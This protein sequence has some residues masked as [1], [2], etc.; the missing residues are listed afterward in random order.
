MLQNFVLHLYWVSLH[1]LFGSAHACSCER[2][3]QLWMLNVFYSILQCYV[4][5]LWPVLF[6][7]LWLLL[8]LSI[9]DVFVLL[10]AH[11]C[12][13]SNYLWQLSEREREIKME[14][15]Q[16]KWN[17]ITE[18]CSKT[19]RQRINKEK[20]KE[21]KKTNFFLISVQNLDAI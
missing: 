4:T 10:L 15:E 16:V 2:W 5:I 20:E 18:M 3:M 14:R 8:L 9:Y 6:V 1:V 7:W 12:F 13:G 19:K 11:I 17:T 21:K